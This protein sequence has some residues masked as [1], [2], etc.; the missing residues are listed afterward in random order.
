MA[1]EIKLP[2]LGENIEEGDVVS[3]MVAEG[4]TVTA[5]QPVLELET[6]KAT[7]EIP[8]SI[9]G[10]IA[11]IHVKEGDKARVGQ[12]I[13]TIEANGAAPA[14]ETP[15]A[16]AKDET[17]AAAE[18]A[19]PAEE[20]AAKQEE[21]AAVGPIDITL[22]ELG[23]GIAEGEIVRVL[24]AEGDAVEPDQPLI[25]IET[26]KATIEVPSTATGTV[27]KVH[28]QEGDKAGIGK[29]VVT[30]EGISVAPKAS[31]PQTAA[32][33][34]AAPAPAPKQAAAA[35]TGAPVVAP[36][37]SFGK[38]VTAAPSVRKFAREIGLLIEEI[39]GTGDR[40][41]ISI[42]DVKAYAKKLN[43]ERRSGGGAAVVAAPLPDF[44]NYGKTES[45]AMNNVRKMTVDHMARCWSLVPHVT[46]HDKADITEL[47]ALR[48]QHGQKAKAAGGK[49]TVT[50]ILI[51]T[52]AAAL[53]EFPDF[54]ASIDTAN[55]QIIYK[56][57]FNIG[58]AVDTPK[59]LVVPVIRGVD[60]KDLVE[61]SV[62]LTEIAT[63]ARDGKIKPND[64]QG[65]CFTV[66]NLGGLGGKHFSPVVN[67]PEVAILGVGRAAQEPV[68]ID[69]AFQPR[70]MMPLSLSYDHRLIDG[71][72]G[73]RFMRWLCDALEN[74]SSL[75][76]EG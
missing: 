52:L 71:A 58:C 65:G 76:I 23:E 44:S 8:S 43:T 63:R 41:R 33:P 42:E 19:A 36:P 16:E 72:N 60:E 35:P 20:P 24:V 62:E 17:P 26:G 34:A 39:P 48:K 7:I 15:A 67:W 74:P 12:L 59:G 14:S 25:E 51:K 57:Y 10:A 46:Q 6:G 29:A 13:L 9:D 11:A 55:G 47:E 61:V 64:M 5:D 31:A 32:A 73:T 69:G 38:R 56:N 50:S 1:T 37:A 49:L 3:I 4:D 27:T 68:Y 22:P 53:K 28:V 70:L 30:I 18:P 54:N 75:S 66:S 40:G 45:K 2:E 21:P